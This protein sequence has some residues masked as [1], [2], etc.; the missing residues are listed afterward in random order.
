MK[1]IQRF[2]PFAL[3][4]LS[5]CATAGDAQPAALEGTQ[6][7]FAQI[8]GAT[9]KSDK[10]RITFEAGRLGATVG[11]NAMGSSWRAEGG[12]IVIDGLISTKMFCQDLAGQE[13]AVSQL[14]D[15][16]PSYRLEAGRLTLSGGGHSATL[17]RD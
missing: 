12:R 10:A 8:D 5:A 17:M 3:L 1:T 4:L 7:R 15:A 6:W 16:S 14:L 11:C 2:A 13:M 9:P